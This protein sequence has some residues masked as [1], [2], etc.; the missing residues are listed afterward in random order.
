MSWLGRVIPD[1]DETAADWLHYESAWVAAIAPRCK[2]TQN[3]APGKVSSSVVV[4]N[5]KR[6]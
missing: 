2:N 3:T 1:P 5:S 4:G 6:K